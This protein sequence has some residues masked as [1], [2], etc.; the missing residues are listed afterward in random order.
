MTS[1][2]KKSDL[3]KILFLDHDG[4]ICL[5]DNYGS[6]FRRR[7]GT[8]YDDHS[9]LNSEIP[10][11]LRFD[12]FDKKAIKILNEILEETNCEIVVSSD[13]RHKATLEEMSELYSSWGIL[14]TPID[15]TDDIFEGFYLLEQSRVSEIM[16]WLKAHPQVTHWVAVDDLH[17]YSDDRMTN[18]VLTSELE[19]ISKPGL[20]NQILE[21]FKPNSVK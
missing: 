8:K 15:F 7:K 13:W 11:D 20:K 10:V 3:M 4:V 19:G 14:K 2:P 6:R 5:L 12:D 17:L 9:I 16:T 18:F 21:F 1:L